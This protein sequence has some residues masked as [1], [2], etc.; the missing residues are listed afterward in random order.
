MAFE[1]LYAMHVTDAA[2]YATY[3]ENMTPILASYGGGFRYDFVVAEVL[4]AEATHPINRVFCIFF[5]DEA[6][7]EAFFE[8][9]AYKHVR[10]T[11]FAPAVAAS[12]CIAT[13]TV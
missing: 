1:M 9:P 10:E 6:A 12:T 5:R 3:R 13:Y 4:K 2:S 11:Y 8:D 7:K